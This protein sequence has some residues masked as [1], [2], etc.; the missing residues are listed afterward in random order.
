M[1]D[2]GPEKA[3]FIDS[4]NVSPMVNMINVFF[5]GN[6]TGNDWDQYVNHTSLY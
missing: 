4:N 2:A 1:T 3:I 5:T 6:D